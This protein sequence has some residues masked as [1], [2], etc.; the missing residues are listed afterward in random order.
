[1]QSLMNIRPV[2]AELL[3]AHGQTDMTKLIF[4]FCNSAQAPK[5]FYIAY[6][7]FVSRNKQRLFLST[8]LAD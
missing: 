7:L 4:T 6:V 1:M 2:E 3:H 8:A 5:E